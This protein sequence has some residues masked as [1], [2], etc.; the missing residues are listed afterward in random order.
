MANA[1]AFKVALATLT[2]HLMA[3]LMLYFQR[4]KQYLQLTGLDATFVWVQC[5]GKSC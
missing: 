2:Q 5:H 1:M 4:L 3:M